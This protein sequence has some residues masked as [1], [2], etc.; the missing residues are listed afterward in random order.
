MIYI[1]LLCLLTTFVVSQEESTE[2][3]IDSDVPE[4]ITMIQNTLEEAENNENPSDENQ[5][6]NPESENNEEPEE[7]K[8]KRKHLKLDEEIKQLNEMVDATKNRT[9]PDK[10]VL[11]QKIFETFISVS[12]DLLKYEY[13]T[14][15]EKSRSELDTLKF[16]YMSTE[17]DKLCDFHKCNTNSTELNN[18]KNDVLS[19]LGDLYKNESTNAREDILKLKVKLIKEAEEKLNSLVAKLN[20]IKDLPQ[21]TAKIK[22]R[23]VKPIISQLIGIY[24]QFKEFKHWKGSQKKLE[25]LHDK[26]K[27]DFGKFKV[28]KKKLPSVAR[29]ID[30]L[31]TYHKRLVQKYDIGIDKMNR[32]FRRYVRKSLKVTKSITKL[33]DKTNNELNTVTGDPTVFSLSKKKRKQRLDKLHKL[34][35]RMDDKKNIIVFERDNFKKFIKRAAFVTM[36]GLFNFLKEDKETSENRHAQLLHLQ[37]A[38]EI[39]RKLFGN[40][41]NISKVK[42]AILMMVNHGTEIIKKINDK[43]KSTQINKTETPDYNQAHELLNMLIQRSMTISQYNGKLQKVN[44]LMKSKIEKI[45][46]KLKIT[47]GKILKNSLDSLI[48]DTKDFI[49][50]MNDTEKNEDNLKIGYNKL[51]E[52]ALKLKVFSPELYSFKTI[53]ENINELHDLLKSIRKGSF[54]NYINKQIIKKIIDITHQKIF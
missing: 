46:F 24:N 31:L 7:I 9:S 45:K 1:S 41:K 49:T 18:V 51:I 16:L 13:L 35:D 39:G 36:N 22:V 25:E 19:N 40:R 32:K 53:S 27:E 21:I 20:E 3:T 10:I 52:A 17:N 44:K 28:H 37:K 4:E 11:D 5:D 30:D 29:I 14:S 42:N 26:L 33:N 54:K 47:K 12:H 50:K 6:E 23:E 2:T 48:D 43:S 34:Y 38:L 8:E 15:D